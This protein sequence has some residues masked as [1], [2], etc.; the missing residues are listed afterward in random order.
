MC[1]E[2]GWAALPA[3]LEMG[4]TSK[5][6][7]AGRV[8]QYVTRPVLLASVEGGES[9][10]VIGTETLAMSSS[11]PSTPRSPTPRKEP[12]ATDATTTSRRMR[13]AARIEKAHSE[14]QG[15]VSLAPGATGISIFTDAQPRLWR[16]FA[17]WEITHDDTDR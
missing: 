11:P 13:S 7:R 2:A 1:L 17:P 4:V 6:R 15:R 16:P 9:A 5:R 12:G 8:V 3:A 10:G 14:A